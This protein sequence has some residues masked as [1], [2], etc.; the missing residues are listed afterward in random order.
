MTDPDDTP[1]TP[2]CPGCRRL[3]EDHLSFRGLGEVIW[4]GQPSSAVRTASYRTQTGYGPQGCNHVFLLVREADL[5]EEEVV[6]RALARLG[7]P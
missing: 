4:D 7:S 2:L 3:V 1:E 6:L 5:P